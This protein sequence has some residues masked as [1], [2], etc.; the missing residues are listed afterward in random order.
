MLIPVGVSCS[1]VVKLTSVLPRST[2]LSLL[3]LSSPAGDGDPDPG[4]WQLRRSSGDDGEEREDVV[5]ASAMI[6][7]TGGGVS[8]VL[9]DSSGNG[10][11]AI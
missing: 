4:L 7:E 8:G 9:L 10:S 11:G 5:D 2:R 1:P 3:R 6:W